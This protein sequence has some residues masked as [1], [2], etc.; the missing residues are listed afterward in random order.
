[1]PL[2]F[3]E[4][5]AGRL[6]ALLRFTGVL[7]GDR[8]LAED[9]VQDVLLKAHHRWNIIASKDSPE[10]YV[11]RM[12]V[13]EYISWRRKW[14]RI[15]P[16]GD[17]TDIVDQTPGRDHATEHADRSDLSDRLRQLPARQRAVIVLRYYE[18]LSHAEVADLLG[19]SVG[20][21][22]GYASRALATMRM[23]IAET[24]LIELA[25][26]TGKAC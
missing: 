2:S 6:P 25:V 5:T 20:T 8:H 12:L 14:A 17:L 1:M 13:N 9:V 11:R 16:T 7:T 23:D 4:F 21:I 18:G 3:D 10:A 26:A 24:N 15:M 22:R 19:C